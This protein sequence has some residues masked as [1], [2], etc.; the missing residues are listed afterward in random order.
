MKANDG[1]SEFMSLEID[2]SERAAEG[3]LE[4]ILADFEPDVIDPSVGETTYSKYGVEPPQWL[5]QAIGAVAAEHIADA[6]NY[7][8]TT[9]HLVHKQ[10]KMV[11]TVAR[12]EEQTPHAL[13]LAAEQRV[14]DLEEA[15]R[16]AGVDPD[17]V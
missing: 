15:L 14:R 4:T 11:L 10:Q 17:T 5:A 8:E 9:F 12:S 13:R 1:K 3:D 6:D 2:L 16:E 7:K